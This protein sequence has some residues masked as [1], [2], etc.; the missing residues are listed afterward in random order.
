MQEV[1][2]RV[3]WADSS[4]PLMDLRLAG[5][6]ALLSFI[7]TTRIISGSQ[8]ISKGCYVDSYPAQKCERLGCERLATLVNKWTGLDLTFYKFIYFTENCFPKWF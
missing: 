6:S 7:F 2:L 8:R 4:T 1:A 3:K 5:V